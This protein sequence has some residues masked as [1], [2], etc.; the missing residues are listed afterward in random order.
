[1]NEAHTLALFKKKI[2]K[3]DDNKDVIELVTALEFMPLTI[4]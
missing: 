1:M 2:G 3:Q 4:I